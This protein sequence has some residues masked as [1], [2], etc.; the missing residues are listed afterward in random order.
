M[1]S[2]I[3]G[4]KIPVAI[5]LAIAIPE[6]L[7]WTYGWNFSHHGLFPR[8]ISHLYGIL[9]M[10]FLHGELGHLANNVSALLVLMWLLFEFYKPIAWKSLLWT[11]LFSGLW[12]WI[13]GRESFHIGASAVVYGLAGF[14][15]VGGIFRKHLP[16]MGVSML[17]LF[18][19]GSIIWGIFP[20]KAGVSWDGH[21]FGLIAGVSLSYLFRKQGPQRKEYSWELEEDDGVEDG[22]WNRPPDQSIPNVDQPKVPRNSPKHIRYIYRSKE[23]PK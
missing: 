5:C 23:P 3:N 10:P 16:L 11:W 8:D 22:Y 1:K 15:F 17:V 7:E 9:T 18:L 14:L 19:Y 4:F 20:V 21:L 13:G 12:L 6:L 2:I